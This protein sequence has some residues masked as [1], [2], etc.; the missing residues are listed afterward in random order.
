MYVRRSAGSRR[1]FLVGTTGTIVSRI[2]RS[3]REGITMG[4]TTG[5]STTRSSIILFLSAGWTIDKTCLE[6]VSAKITEHSLH[7]KIKPQ[8]ICT[9][10]HSNH[11][12]SCVVVSEVP[13]CNFLLC[14]QT[15]CCVLRAI[16]CCVS[17]NILLCRLEV[18][19]VG[20]CFKR[21]W[22]FELHLSSAKV[23]KSRRFDTCLNPN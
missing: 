3:S 22:K 20:A 9:S 10:S 23:I 6:R 15:F 16:L 5:T 2:V 21:G 11:E 12:T 4:S 17:N 13:A 1:S 14:I 18:T 8:Y 7:Y 19:R